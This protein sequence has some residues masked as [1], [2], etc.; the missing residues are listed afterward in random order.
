M[1]AEGSVLASVP[2][3]FQFYINFEY[4]LLYTGHEE[5]V[6]IKAGF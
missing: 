3:R 5:V 1:L 6:G 2:L 4:M